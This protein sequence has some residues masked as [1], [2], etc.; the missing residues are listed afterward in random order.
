M[1]LS[2]VYFAMRCLVQ[3]VVRSGRGDLEREV[4][5]LVLRHQLKVLSRGA[6]RPPFCRRDR[7]L[8]AA[9]SRILPRGTVAGV[10]RDSPDPAPVARGA[11]PTQVD[12]WPPRAGQARTR[13]GN[14]GAHHSPAIENPRVG[15]PQNPRGAHPGIWLSWH[16]RTKGC[17]IDRETLHQFRATASGTETH[18]A[19][20][21]S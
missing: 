16:R 1:V 19:T 2:L 10:R 3:A 5:L 12:L 20:L 4:E 8:V 17:R 21:Y 18:A 9:V 11:G 6:R 7:M 15:L 14:G 13:S